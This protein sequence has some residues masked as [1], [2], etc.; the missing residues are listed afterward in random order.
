[1]STR[2]G[3][4]EPCCAAVALASSTGVGRQATG[5]VCL[6]NEGMPL[7]LIIRTG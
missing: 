3:L 1:M 7:A 5:T 4:L 2:T 6:V